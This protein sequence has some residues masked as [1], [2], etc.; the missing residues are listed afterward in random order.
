MPSSALPPLKPMVTVEIRGKKFPLC[1][2]VAALDVINDKCSGI[3]GIMDFLRGN[4]E[5]VEGLNEDQ[6]QQL[7][8]EAASRAKYNNAWML[9]LLI[10]EGE[11]NRIMEARF[12]GSDTMRRAVPGPEEMVH[13]LTP[14]QVSGYQLAILQAVNESLKRTLEATQKNV[15]QG[16]EG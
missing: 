1:L 3:G 4:P 15:F 2:T 12:D 6:L 11:E 16:A 5:Q 8:M 14:G 7:A 13:L 9:G 10:Q